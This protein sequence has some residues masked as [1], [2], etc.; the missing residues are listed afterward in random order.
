MRLNSFDEWSPLREVIV[1]S[2][3]GY[4]A[5]EREHSFDM[6]LHEN[7]SGD[8][9]ASRKPWLYPPFSPPPG[10][11]Q[12]S[13]I[14][15]AQR[16]VDELNEDIAGLVQVL[17]SLH[18]TVHRPLDIAAQAP[19]VSTPAWSATMLPALNVRDNL[20]VL[21]DEAVETPPMMRSRYFENQLLKPILLDYFRQG[22][23]WS[24]MPRPLLTDGSFDYSYID[25]AA[26]IEEPMVATTRP[27][28][29]PYHVGF[30]M[31]MDAAQIIR[32]GMDVLVNVST[33]HHQLAYDWLARHFAGRLRLHRLYR[34]SDDHIDS[35]VLPLRPGLL[36]ARSPQIVDR[37][38]AAL[39]RWDRIYYPEP[40]A[41]A[42]PDYDDT[43]LI[44]SSKYIDMNVLSVDP[45]TV[46]VN[47]A[48]HEMLRLLESKGLTA[49]PVRH[50]HRRLFGG[51]FHCFTVD[52]V[53]DG[54]P[55]D[56]LS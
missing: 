40:A 26:S 44:L 1:G 9:D 3:I 21:G 7:I 32:I 34:L 31:M 13:R 33:A 55:E 16:H 18:V 30:E 5:H 10:A 8:N 47:S 2:G 29:S 41:D 11:P 23:R 24:V 53:R 35:T 54:G 42:F 12:R 51:G 27:D 25:D 50:R 56:Y 15:I 6:F 20:V 22:A 37:L 14:A 46:L 36:L 38:P 52:T 39:Q 4:T 45:H 28:T 17:Q 43:A 19:Q 49:I 48:H